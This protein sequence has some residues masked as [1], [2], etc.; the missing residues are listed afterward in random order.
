VDPISVLFV[1]LLVVLFVAVVAAGIYLSRGWRNV[2]REQVNFFS[3]EPSFVCPS[4]SCSVD[5]GFEV[6]TTR[7]DTQVLLQAIG[8][9]GTITDLSSSLTFA[10]STNGA[11]AAFWTDGPGDYLFRLQVTGA[12]IGNFS[13]TLK[14]T[15]FTPVGGVIAHQARVRMS[16]AASPQEAR[17]SFRLTEFRNLKFQEYTICEKSAE[18][19][20]IRYVSGGI[21]GHDRDLNVTVRNSDGVILLDLPNMQPGDEAKVDPPI[22]IAGGIQIDGLMVGGFVGDPPNS[23]PNPFAATDTVPWDLEINVRCI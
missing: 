12:Q 19:T 3:V 6:E 8:P 4:G 5:I 7:D 23:L 14:A 10:R 2:D 1:V 20:A 21:G 18:I 16:E 17:D 9:S 22:T 15:L 11:E 13:K